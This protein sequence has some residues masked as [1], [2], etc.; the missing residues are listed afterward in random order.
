MP[1][2]R[3]GRGRPGGSAA[4]IA[5]GPPASGGP[6]PPEHPETRNRKPSRTKT[7]AKDRGAGRPAGRREEHPGRRP[8]AGRTERRGPTS[9]SGLR[10]N[11]QGRAA[12]NRGPARGPSRTGS[13]PFIAR[14]AVRRDRRAGRRPAGPGGRPRGAAPV[15][16]RPAG[17]ERPGAAGGGRGPR[18]CA[19]AALGR[20]W[21][22]PGTP[23]AIASRNVSPRPASAPGARWTSG[24][25]KAGSGSTAG[26]PPRAPGSAPAIGCGSTAG[27]SSCRPPRSAGCSSI[28]SRPARSRPAGTPRGGARSSSVL[29]RLRSERWVAAGRL[30]VNTSG[31]ML[32][33]TD[34]DL[35][36]RLMHPRYGIEREYAVRVLGP[37]GAP[38]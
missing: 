20:P 11:P 31:L 36:H 17:P 12:A 34:G 6:R 37:G 19:G 23:R 18:P 1:A 38:R 15:V 13:E 14:E 33:A 8:P 22:R 10:K 9:E 28:T 21:K 2:A 29:P 3:A 32:F 7:G 16:L 26:W 30:D 27:A 24:W 5:A 35:V 4:K 25:R